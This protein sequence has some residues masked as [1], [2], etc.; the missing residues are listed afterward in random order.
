MQRNV[1]FCYVRVISPDSDIFF[2]LLHY[3]LKINGVTLLFDTGKGNDKHLINVTEI[4]S[5]YGQEQCTALLVLHAFTGCDS[6]SAFVGRGKMR[7]I[8]TLKR[9]PK[10]IPTFAQ[11]DEECDIGIMKLIEEFVCKMYGHPRASSIDDVRF[12]MLKAK[13]GGED[14]MID[15]K[16]NIDFSLLPPCSKS[17]QQHI[18]RTNYQVSI[19]KRSHIR[20]PVIP[21][22]TEGN[23][24][25]ISDSG[26]M[27]PKWVEG[28][29]NILPQEIVDVLQESIDEMDSDDDEEIM[30]GRAEFSDEDDN[31]SDW[32]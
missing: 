9:F 2:I 12:N 16:K 32:Y 14:G 18:L 13:C 5:K 31:D 17:L 11:L 29:P 3:A 19:W 27:E 1:D 15:P 26:F 7:P 10:Y 28:D 8:Q 22:P 6:T 23:G 30:F 24:W 25:V 4:A 21:K 20:F